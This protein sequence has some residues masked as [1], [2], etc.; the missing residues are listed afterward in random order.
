MYCKLNATAPNGK[1]SKLWNDLVG[2]YRDK[3]IVKGIYCAVTDKS[4]IDKH[5]DKLIFD[6]NGEP[7]MDSV[8]MLA[9]KI[10]LNTDAEAAV[11]ENRFNNNRYNSVK[12]FVAEAVKFNREHDDM[13]A[14]PTQT[15]DNK[16]SVRKAGLDS[17]ATKKALEASLDEYEKVEA[18]LNRFGLDVSILDS[19]MLDQEDAL[20]NPQKLGT[21]TKGLSGV[22]NIA[23]N[24]HGFN[25]LTEEFSHLL[26]EVLRAENNPLVNR[27]ES[28]LMA[29]EQIVKDVLGDEY[30][31]IKEY[32]DSKGTPEYLYTEALG[33][34]VASIVNGK[35]Q[36]GNDIV[37]RAANAVKR[38]IDSV[39]RTNDQALLDDV[40]ALV[41]ELDATVD[42]FMGRTELKKEILERFKATGR[43]LAHT[44]TAIDE[45]NEK[46]QRAVRNAENN[47]IK[48]LNI[49]KFDEERR[50][51]METSFS[52]IAQYT[53]DSKFLEGAI[54][55]FKEIDTILHDN[56][57][58]LEEVTLADD[59]TMV[60]LRAHG[61]KLWA[62]KNLVDCYRE[63]AVEIKNVLRE[64]LRTEGIDDDVRVIAE[65]TLNSVVP[66]I[67][68]L[69]NTVENE[70]F[71]LNRKLI[72]MY[73]KPFFNNGKG[74]LVV[75][76]GK[77]KGEIISLENIIDFTNGD[78]NM[79]SRM[80]FSASNTNDMY[81]QLCDHI[82]QN[83]DEE[84]RAAATII[85][86]K[87]QVLDKE[88]RSAM[89]GSYD[90]SFIYE[91]DD[92]GNKTGNYVSEYKIWL[93]Q[94]DMQAEE[95]RLK[96]LY[97]NENGET[98]DDKVREE[99]DKWHKKNSF[100]KKFFIPKWGK[101]KTFL[102]PNPSIEKY[103][104]DN[105]RG[106]W[107]QAQKDYYD[108]YM[109]LKYTELDPLLP[110]SSTFPHRAIQMMVAST[111][112][113]I[114]N[115]DSGFFG[116]VKNAFS[117]IADNY[118]RITENDNGE[119]YDGTPSKVK[120]YI[121]TLKKKF[122]A[123]DSTESSVML[124]FDKRVYKRVPTFFLRSLED[125]SKLSTDATSA[126][127][128]YSLMACHYNGMHKIAD[129]MELFREHAKSKRK[130]YDTNADGNRMKEIL[131]MRI[132]KKQHTAEMDSEIPA[133]MS[134]TY[135]RL[136][137]L[138]DMRL[139][140]Q[141]KLQGSRIL[142]TNLTTGK[143]IDDLIKVTS[144]SL[145]GYSAFSGI[146]NVIMAKQQMFIESMGGQYFNMKD[147]MKADKEFIKNAGEMFAELYLPYTT[148]KLGLFVEWFNVGQN[149]REHIKNSKAYKNNFEQFMSNFGPS[150]LLESG[151]F[152]IQMSTAIATLLGYKLY[153]GPIQKDDKGN[154]TNESVSLYDAIEKYD[155]KNKKGIVVDA[156]LKLKDEYK[157]YVKE[158]GTKFVF[159]KSSDDVKKLSMLI[160]AINQRMHGIYNHEDQNVLTRYG[161][162]RLV[163][164]FR[165]HMVPQLLNRYRGIGT[166]KPFYNFR[167]G[168]F[169]EGYMVTAVRFLKSLVMSN[170]DIRQ[171]QE[172]GSDRTSGATGRM[173]VAWGA[174]TKYEKANVKKA[175]AEILELI[176]IG[177]LLS[178]MISH[179]WD[180]D[181]DWFKRQ[182]VYFTLRAQ[183]ETKMPYSGQSF[184]DVLISPSAVISQMQRYTKF[185]GSL[186][187]G[188]HVLKSGPYKGHTVRYAN[189]MRALP[190]YP[191]M[192]DFIHI[193]D[194]DR[195]FLPFLQNT[196]MI[197][198]WLKDDSEEE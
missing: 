161:I 99:M 120:A 130:I 119:Y 154:I 62:L 78:I 195:R 117:S 86:H 13:I 166:S 134:Q 112:E 83:S 101:T 94:R 187:T 132:N 110:P 6:D 16:M 177:L 173:A 41:D 27:A 165:K 193:A 24:I 111:G 152:S 15:G 160:G 37:G 66:N 8:E 129:V 197:S 151:E 63:P 52:R 55:F 75:P 159:S 26:V 188:G 32:Y 198:E 145:L 18:I 182:A 140:R 90:T 179:D 125:M 181:D 68:D 7:T 56:I 81:V 60:Q 70:F 164:L 38:L 100:R 44:S 178:F 40:K 57:N 25:S 175:G 103:R 87:I 95:D 17:A 147:W 54:A 10:T 142:N 169:E 2:K 19:N 153:K 107:S 51:E 30:E 185:A 123:D 12:E 89:G 118:F 42:E 21:M 196:N 84:I 133:E 171:A 20:M 128:E 79:L 163:M 34:I 61:R 36:G 102:Y 45:V 176:A 50:D 191:N 114:L 85:D 146:N 180:D 124:T 82:I 162:G 88:L 28:L 98:D 1:P 174:L 121:E 106:G 189:F 167:T 168:E 135:Q 9:Q 122:M 48:Y 22:V 139:Y 71:D 156:K 190:V 47:I 148:S 65:S 109:T 150:C 33:R 136:E 157:D 43:V 53:K 137:E 127:R 113:A 194:D 144:F 115:S 58:A 5:G 80:L 149:W 46:L 64:M 108:K 4:Y 170:N 141:A 11:W 74:D 3:N 39:F 126:L 76:F 184:M 35:L 49:Y 105:Y 93:W 97:T 96:K 116:G 143:V 186:F 158:D 72:I 73:A 23:N 31:R 131:K 67:I 155:V 14:V 192:Y 77:H 29:N 138:F 69:I 59:L 172:E 183:T 91:R 92:K 104:N